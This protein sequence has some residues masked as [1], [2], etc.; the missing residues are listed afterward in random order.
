MMPPI[1][2]PTEQH[3]EAAI[4]WQLT[5]TDAPFS[6]QQQAQFNA[7]LAQ[8]PRHQLAWQRIHELHE[9]AALPV[10]QTTLQEVA[11]LQQQNV[12]VTAKH[13]LT[14]HGN[15]PKGLL[16]ALLCLG[17]SYAYLHQ[18]Q[19]PAWALADH[20]S[21]RHQVKTI[22][23]PDGSQLQ[24][25]GSSAVDVD[26]TA[27]QRTIILRKGEVVATVAKDPNRPFVVYSSQGSATALGTAF[28]VKA[29][30]E[31][32]VDVTVL[33]SKVQ[34]CAPATDAAQCQNLGANGY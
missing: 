6:P 11:A 32:V 28:S 27:T 17:L 10:A 16:L 19:W 25:A 13:Y 3:I 31:H 26:Y 15:K 7:W 21:V 1:G 22:S 18:H 34:V 4:V 5:L 20:R 14:E 33:S 8:D 29:W 9:L 24:L 12:F 30:S 2:E 23:L